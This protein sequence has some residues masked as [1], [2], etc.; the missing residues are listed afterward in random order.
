M[1]FLTLRPWRHFNAVDEDGRAWYED[2]ISAKFVRPVEEAVRGAL[3]NADW[4]ALPPK[5]GRGKKTLAVIEQRR[6]P[7]ARPGT[8]IVARSREPAEV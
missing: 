1:T 4:D 3:K 8:Q 6:A 2:F 5:T 7:A